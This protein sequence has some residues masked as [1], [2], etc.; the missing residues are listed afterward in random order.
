MNPWI[1]LRKATPEFLDGSVGR[2]QLGALLA[3]CCLAT[4]AWLLAADWPIFRNTSN[5][6]ASA[7]MI[8]LPLT[9]VWH[10]TAPQ[11]EE[12]GV[13][14]ANGIAY[15]ISQDGQLHAFTVSSGFEVA[16]FPVQAAVTFGTPAVDTANGRIY[17]LA[18]AQLFGFN[19]DGTLAFPGISVGSTG[20]NY[21]QGPILDGGFV[22]FEA[23]GM[24]QK[25]NS[26]G[27]AQWTSA[28]A[29]D[30]TQPAINGNFVYKNTEAGQIRK[31][32]KVTGAEVLGGGFPIA[33]TSSQSSLA[34]VN[35]R[36]FHKSDELHVYG[37]NTG[38]PLWNQPIGGTS[39]YYNSPAV[40]NGAVYVYGWDSR[41][42]AF[43]EST[44]AT[45]AG[46]PSVPLATDGDRNYSSPA[47]AGDKVFVAAGT[48]QKLKVVGAAGSAQAGLVLE[49]HLTFST[50]PQGFDLCS[51]VISDGY[52]FAMLDGGGL[53]AFFGGS[54]PPAG[55]LQ[56]NGGA[57]CTSSR[58][59]TLT[60]DNNNN[61]NVTEMRISEDPF[62][63]DTSFVPYQHTVPFTLSAGFGMKTVYAQLRDNQHILSNV[64]T[65]SINYEPN[66]ESSPSPTPT[67][68]PSVTPASQLFNVSTRAFVQTGDNVIIGGFIIEGTEPERVIIRAIGP[69]LTGFG[70]PNVL[71][72]PTLELHDGTGAL[73]AS[74]DNWQ[75]TIIGG[76]IPHDQSLE[77]RDSGHAPGNPLESAI[78]AN[79]PA[80]NYTAI[81]RGVNNTM[82]I[83]L[84]E[85]YD[86][87]PLNNSILRNISTRGLVQTGDNVMIGGFIVQG[88]GPKR[89]IIRAIGPELSAPPYNVPNPLPDPVLELH[90]GTGALIASN[91]DWQHT[92]IGG[93]ITSDQVRDIQSSGYAPRNGTESAIIATLPPGNYTGIVRGKNIVIGIALVEVY[94]LD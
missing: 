4:G 21:S 91:D 87:S 75:F 8:S 18:T 39:T 76:I 58:N 62:F 56:I 54:N 40:A 22:Y 69:E 11:V 52:V 68:T 49:E 23:G 32:D 44:G 90:D 80:G 70:V 15:M 42:Y 6:G 81:V 71:I 61:P 47:V 33:T 9:E 19:L 59:V 51:P 67:A 66:C 31:F 34:V 28:S 24:L 93:I 17:V 65:A 37:A 82:G 85:A 41:L 43:D 84:V 29:G 5:A 2:W 36:I 77:I 74:N 3:L 10:S 45:L 27:T 16:G 78:I 60:I 7:E 25:Y 1:Q 35:G 83:G 30:N 50:D 14:V 64:F 94:D 89:V 38:A 88:T 92:I 86:L 20:T 55:A 12:N 46:F 13:V 48:T 72:N 53:Y 26:S 63:G 57:T 73:I 79:L